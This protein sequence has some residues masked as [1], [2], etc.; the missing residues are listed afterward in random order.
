MISE[1]KAQASRDNG[2]RT[3]G[4]VSPNGK[5]R[6]R[7]NA[8]K[9][10]LFTRELIIP[11]V[12]ESQEELD[13][14]RS[15]VWNHFQPRDVVSE[16]LAGEII[17]TYWRLQR[18]RRCEAAEI[19][20]QLITAPYRRL[21]QKMSEVGSLKSRFLANYAVRFSTSGSGA[22][23]PQGIRLS[24][25]ETRKQLEQSSLGLEFL[26]KRLK[27]VKD[28]ASTR[29]YISLTSEVMLVDACGIEDEIAHAC[30]VLNKNTYVELEKLK[31][32]RGDTTTFDESKQVLCGML[33]SK[34]RDLH[35]MK[36]VIKQLESAEE[37]A[38]LATLV[39]PPAECLERI[40]RAE[41]AMERRFYRALNQLLALQN[42][43]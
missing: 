16:M 3:K 14:L 12:G 5:A 7:L 29:G 17:S 1:K 18:P 27:G 21:Y 11:S 24:Q 23:D 31:D 20:K 38:H 6:V 8:L 37:K 19:R 26:I 43:E 2:R 4:P 42:P 10:G 36:N 35:M 34:I 33:N 9:D 39:L 32:K 30:L 40:H 15:T 25:E 22:A 13:Q 28:E 41:A